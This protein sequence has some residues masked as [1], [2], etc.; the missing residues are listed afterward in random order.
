MLIYREPLPED[1][2][3]PQAEEIAGPRIVYRM[4][5]S[6][7]PIDDDFRSQRAKNPEKIYQV[8]ECRARGLSVYA[9][10]EDVKFLAARLGLEGVYFCRVAL[11]TGAGRIQKTGAASHHTWW[12]RAAF[13]ILAH[14]QVAQ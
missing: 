13:D 5:W 7:P 9:Q 2:P 14:C 3:P 11:A 1:C 12:P 6:D 10:L 8:T 4:V